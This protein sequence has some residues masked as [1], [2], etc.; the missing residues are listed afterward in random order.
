MNVAKLELCKT[1]YELSEWG[2]S[3]LAGELHPDFWY[4]PGNKLPTYGNRGYL[5]AI[6]AYDCGYLLRKLPRHLTIKNQLYH[7]C[8]INGNKQDDNWIADYVTMGREC[9]LHEGDRAQLTEDAEI[10]NALCKLAIE[11]IKQGIIKT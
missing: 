9:W 1:L 8:I 4:T 11:L 5:K 3:A 7:L 10:E 2:K 6:P